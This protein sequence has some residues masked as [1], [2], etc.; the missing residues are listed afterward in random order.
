[1]IKLPQNVKKVALFGGTFD[2]I[3]I[4]HL[5]VAQA[6]VEEKHLDWLIFIPAAISPFKTR[7]PVAPAD[8]RVKFLRLALAGWNRCSIDLIEIKKG[9][10]SYTIETVR[11]Y[12]QQ[13]P[14]AELFLIIG[15]DHLSLLPHWKD[16]DK[17]ANEV[18]FVVAPRPGVEVKVPKGFKIEFLNSVYV[19]ISST[20][21]RE[22]I[23][24]GRSWRL[25][26]PEPVA[27]AIESCM[28]YKKGDNSCANG[29]SQING[30][31]RVGCALQ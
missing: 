15:A 2:P 17:L 7:H 10:I 8:C 28:C 21:L 27:Q 6:A 5:L 26:L 29:A 19:G 22:R 14:E 9:G 12:R 11:Q 3:H 13:L 30:V 4:G 16:A 18:T 25:W 23:A 1:M 31:K 24:T 20:E